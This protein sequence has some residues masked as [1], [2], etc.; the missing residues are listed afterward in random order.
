M[1]TIACSAPYGAGGL[2]QHFTQLV[3]ESRT[4]GTLQQYFAPRVQEGDESHAKVITEW[5]SPWVINYTPIR[6]SP[7]WKNYACSDLFDRAVAA[8]LTPAKGTYVGFGGQSLYSF[9]RARSLGYASLELQAANSHVRN[10]SRRHAEALRQWPFEAS[11]LNETQVQK[12]LHEYEMADVIVAASQYT[13]DSLVA[14]GVPAEKL[15]LSPLKV[16]PRFVPPTRRPNDGIFRVIYVGSVTVMKGI[17]VL[18]EAFSRLKGDNVELTLVGGWATR[19]MKKYVREWTAKDSR[20]KLIPG[21]PLP[22]LHNADVYVHPT[23]EDGFAYAAAEAVA[24]GVP[25]VVTEDTGMK[26]MVRE[27][28]NG[29]IVPTGSWKAILERLEFIKSRSH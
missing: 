22:H 18:L 21:D 12:T 1:R 28:V 19:G 14:E 25:V 9:R 6:Y 4:S 27:G 17:P 13:W 7:G 23:F 10:V 15:R 11:W 2:G 29:Y 5:V 24:C 3:E 26:D 20:I 8:Q 16:H